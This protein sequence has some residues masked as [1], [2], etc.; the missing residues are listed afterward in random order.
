MTA[1][2]STARGRAT[3]QAIVDGARAVFERD[4]FLDARITDIA[5]EAGVATG[6]FYTYFVDKSAV[7]AA[8]LGEVQEELLHPRLSHAGHHERFV[9]LLAA[10]HRAYLAVYRDNARLMALREQVATIDPDF[11]E[12]RRRRGRPFIDRNARTIER[13]Q[14]AGLADASLDP[15]LAARTISGMVSRAAYSAFVL[16]DDVDFDALVA[17]VTRLWMGALGIPADAPAD[18]VVR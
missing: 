6:S 1:G 13:L 3:R 4:G 10:S 18:A 5:A 11:R 17:T 7:L 14:A 2:P 15:D 9:D 16:G 12:L 8:V